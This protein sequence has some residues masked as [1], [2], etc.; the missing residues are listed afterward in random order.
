MEV[1]NC[2]S[3]LLPKASAPKAATGVGKFECQAFA[4]HLPRFT[5]LL[6]L[7]L[8]LPITASSYTCEHLPFST[9]SANTF[10]QNFDFFNTTK[11]TAR[12]RCPSP[13]LHSWLHLAFAVFRAKRNSTVH[14]RNKQLHSAQTQSVITSNAVDIMNGNRLPPGPS[15]SQ[16]DGRMN[17]DR[18]RSQYNQHNQHQHQHYNQQPAPMYNGY[19]QPYNP[20]SYNPPYNPAYHPNPMTHHQGYYPY[21]PPY[22]PQYQN[23]GL[24]PAN[25]YAGYPP[26]YGRTP[27]PAAP[28]PQ[29]NPN[30]QFIPAA[31]QPRPQPPSVQPSPIVSSTDYQNTPNYSQIPEPPRTSSQ[32]SARPSTPP[33][34]QIT[35]PLYAE[36]ESP[37]PK[38]RVEI[39]VPPV[40]YFSTPLQD[41][42]TNMVRFLGFL[43]HH[44]CHG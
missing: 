29:Y 4:P 19:A 15:M 27:P 2:P 33:L 38:Q 26:T 23:P 36:P 41:H 24:S 14:R 40:S 32:S 25:N 18:R 9:Y 17:Q 10:S 3:P 1:V 7:L 37:E 8:L 28:I 39:F 42:L 6:T 44:G 11:A 13:S 20:A 21:P 16:Q 31:A 22:M 30:A 43:R 35:E 34:P 12:R 5:L